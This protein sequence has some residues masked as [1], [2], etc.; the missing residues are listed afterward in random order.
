[1]RSREAVSFFGVALMAVTGGNFVATPVSS[2][3]AS[4]GTADAIDGGMGSQAGREQ[5]S[6]SPHEGE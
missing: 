1:M 4:T 6:W 2:A 3:L 5:C